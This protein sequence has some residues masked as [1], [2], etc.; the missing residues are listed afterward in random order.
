VWWLTEEALTEKVVHVAP[1]NNL[2]ATAFA[3]E[4]VAKALIQRKAS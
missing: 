4:V 1:G 2:A 3:A